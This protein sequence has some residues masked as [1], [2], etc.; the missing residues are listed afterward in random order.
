MVNTPVIQSKRTINYHQYGNLIKLVLFTGGAQGL[1]QALGLI[2][3]III[4]R[5]LSIEEYAYYTLANT[6]LGAMIALTDG[7]IS[8]GVMSEGGKVWQEKSKLGIVLQTGLALRRKFAF[9]SL[10]IAVPILLY[11]LRN[12]DASWV[13]TFLII[14]AI[15]P[16][17]FAALSGSL[18]NIIPRLNQTVQPLQKN[19][20]GVAAGRLLMTVSIIFIFPFTAVAIIASGIPQIIGNIGIKKLAYQNAEETKETSI[21]IRKKILQKVNRMLPETIYYCLSSQITYWIISF[22]G[23][24]VALASLGALARI[25]TIVTVFI[26]IFNMLFTPR[27]ARLPESKIILKKYLL[28]VSVL[29]IVLVIL[30][31]TTAYFGSSPILWLLG[32]EYK[33]LNKELLLSIGGS[34]ASLLTQCF[35]ALNTSRGWI[36]HP[37]I[38]ILISII[39]TTVSIIVF[40]M[41][42]LQGALYFGIVVASTQALTLIVYCYNKTLKSSTLPYRT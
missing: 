27:F 23:S 22:I 17:F 21:Q 34:C 19:Q 32:D 36:I 26:M 10:M 4:I 35:F 33:G 1:I 9:V 11:L 25:G 13:N 2:C 6:M 8:A 15:L 18:L 7:G 39:S 30:I 28:S 20:I 5:M 14:A 29:L 3:G 41:G 24:T 37:M 38:Y 40:D 42:T 31:L 12:Q 16:A